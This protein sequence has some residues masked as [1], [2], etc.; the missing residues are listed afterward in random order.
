ML[1]IKNRGVNNS[2][3]YLA[4]EGFTK[5]NPTAIA[6]ENPPYG[7][8]GGS[9]AALDGTA[10]DGTYIATAGNGT[11]KVLGLFLNDAEGQPWENAP[12]V[13]SGKVAVF[14]RGDCEVDLYEKVT[15]KVGDNLYCSENGFLTNVKPSEASLSISDSN[16]AADDTVIGIVTKVPTAAEPLLGVKML[17]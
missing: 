11:N 3:F 16:A 15:Y 1:N 13:A 6:G 10:E 5:V 12:A 14:M 8:L 4:A 9:V 2:L 7:V 17:I